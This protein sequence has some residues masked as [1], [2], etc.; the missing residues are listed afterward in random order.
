MTK[1]IKNIINIYYTKY[2]HTI[3]LYSMTN[4]RTLFHIIF[5]IFII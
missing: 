4:L 1:Y 2:I 3:N 5:F